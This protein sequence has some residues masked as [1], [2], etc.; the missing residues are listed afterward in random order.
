MVLWENILICKALCSKVFRSDRAYVSNLLLLSSGGGGVIFLPF[1]Y[2]PCKFE[3]VSK[4]KIY[5]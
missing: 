3:I 5:V 1:F 4:I 2:L